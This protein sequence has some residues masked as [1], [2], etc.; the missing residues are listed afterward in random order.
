MSTFAEYKSSITHPQ[1]LAH[2]ELV[3][4]ALSLSGFCSQGH[5]ITTCQQAGYSRKET[6]ALITTLVSL[7]L[8]ELSVT[9]E[10]PIQV[11]VAVCKGAELQGVLL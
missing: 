4:A 9:Q 8:V 10:A 1:Q 2:V 11:R 3:A 5:L 7:G 6:R